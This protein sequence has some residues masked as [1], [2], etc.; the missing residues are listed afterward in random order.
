MAITSNTNSILTTVNNVP[1]ATSNN[2]NTVSDYPLLDEVTK[3]TKTITSLSTSNLTAG[4]EGTYYTTLS[5][6]DVYAHVSYINHSTPSSQ[7]YKNYNLYEKML[8]TTGKPFPTSISKSTGAI[9]L[10]I[11]RSK[12]NHGIDVGNYDLSTKSYNLRVGDTTYLLVTDIKSTEIEGAYAIKLGAKTNYTLTA[13]ATVYGYSFPTQGI[14]ILP[15]HPDGVQNAVFSSITSNLTAAAVF[16]IAS[17]AN[18]DASLANL[19]VFKRSMVRTYFVRIPHNKFNLSTNPTWTSSTAETNGT[20]F[21]TG[22]AMFNSNK[23]LV[24]IAKL[25]KALIKNNEKEWNLHVK[26]EF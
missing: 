5:N 25:D 3:P 10:S 6:G 21:I 1:S 12:L 4:E 16:T 9:V 23:E 24:A 13:G 18:G 8:M 15:V 22:V 11:K 26:L 2:N 19:K 20:T 17:G 14:I 7:Y